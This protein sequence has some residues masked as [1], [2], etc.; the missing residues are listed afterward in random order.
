MLITHP[1]GTLVLLNARDFGHFGSFVVPTAPSAQPLW[2]REAWGKARA[3][4]IHDLSTSRRE[5]TVEP[6]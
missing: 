3:E 5:G 1:V 6:G 2:R 4:A